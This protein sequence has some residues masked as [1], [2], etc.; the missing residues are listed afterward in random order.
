MSCAVTKTPVP[1]SILTTLV[2][3]AVEAL[4]RCLTRNPDTEWAYLCD[5]SVRQIFKLK[6]EGEI[7]F[8]A[9]PECL[10]SPR[11]FLLADSSQRKGE[12]CGYRNIQMLSSYI[13]D[14][15]M[16]G[17][18]HFEAKIP[19]IFD[20]QDAVETAWEQGIRAEGLIE[21]GGIRGTRKYIGTPEV[22]SSPESL[23]R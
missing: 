3:G 18:K 8:L 23:P 7:H 17:S 13:I 11:D 5:P 14:S 4:M 19:S 6:R 2:I 10:L 1:A 15:G 9:H 22:S 20:I 21:T 12:F 16:P